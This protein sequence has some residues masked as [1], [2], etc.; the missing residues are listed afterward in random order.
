M[1]TLNWVIGS[2]GQPCQSV[3]VPPSVAR[4]IPPVELLV[5]QGN[6]VV[7]IAGTVVDKDTVPAQTL[8]IKEMKINS[9][10]VYRHRNSLIVYVTYAH[11][12]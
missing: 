10:V 7:G 6:V 5:I 12:V 1:Q 4:G 2:L 11:V 9:M 3:S 8:E